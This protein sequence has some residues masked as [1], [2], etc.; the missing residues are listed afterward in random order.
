MLP[1]ALGDRKRMATSPGDLERQWGTE[2]TG[3]IGVRKR[4]TAHLN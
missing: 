2:K 4:R 1:G 3:Q